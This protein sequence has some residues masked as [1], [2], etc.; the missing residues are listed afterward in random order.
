[1]L[2][3]NHILAHWEMPV[4]QNWNFWQGRI[5]SEKCI[6]GRKQIFEGKQEVMEIP[7]FN[8]S[9]IKLPLSPPLTFHL[10][11][12]YRREEITELRWSSSKELV[13]W[14]EPNWFIVCEPLG[15]HVIHS[16]KTTLCPTCPS[17][18]S[19]HSFSFPLLLQNCP[20]FRLL[21]SRWG[22]HSITSKEN[23]CM[24]TKGFF[25]WQPS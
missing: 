2:H 3:L 6:K 19:S 4:H 18:S 17:I 12:Q 22:S 9:Q 1:M 11:I 25:M 8:N 13:V 15:F 24:F 16:S 14:T 23:K 20:K 5:C 7:Y 10:E 21:P